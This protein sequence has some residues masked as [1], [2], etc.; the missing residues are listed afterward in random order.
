MQRAPHPSTIFKIFSPSDW[1]DLQRDGQTLGSALDRQ[2]GFLHFSTEGQ[3]A[4]TL[5]LHFRGAGPLVLARIPLSRLASRDVRW[6]P[7]RDGSLFPHLYGVLH[8]G[9]IDRH[10]PL[11]PTDKD[12]Y[13]L[14]DLRAD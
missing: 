9:E 2:D 13:E 10:W 3:L 8:Q 7:A 11:H 12:R 5:A 4:A 6:E 1:E 14:P